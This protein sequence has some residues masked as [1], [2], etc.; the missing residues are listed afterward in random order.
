MLLG[1]R[2]DD[3]PPVHLCLL[4]ALSILAD[5]RIA[6]GAPFDTSGFSVS[7]CLAALGPGGD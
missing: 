6:A 4:A 1:S 7:T 2:P 5:V 3:D